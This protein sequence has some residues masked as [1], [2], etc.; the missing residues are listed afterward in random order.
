MPTATRTSSDPG[1]ASHIHLEVVGSPR[2]ARDLG[3]SALVPVVHTPGLEALDPQAAYWCSGSWAARV[4]A[5]G[6]HPFLSPGPAWLARL[7]EEFLARPLRSGFLGDLFHPWRRPLFVS[8]AQHESRTFH[9]RVH[10]D[11]ES[12]LALALSAFPG[13]SL[14]ELCGLATIVSQPVVFAQE[15]RCFLARARVTSVSHTRTRYGGAETTWQAHG[16]D[17]GP[18]TRDAQR[19]AQEVADAVG[20]DQAPG[21]CLDVGRLD[22]GR[23]AVIDARPAWSADPCRGDPDGT[24]AAILSSQEENPDWGWRPD[25]LTA[26]AAQPL[27]SPQILVA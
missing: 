17:E 14:Q 26:A 19:F 22:V 2:I 15:F 9:G 13:R 27:P 1:N 10:S 16:R 20:P 12:L 6:H 8:L 3:A 24:V 5:T 18:D 4:V 7:P 11:A 25:P 21:Y 23:W